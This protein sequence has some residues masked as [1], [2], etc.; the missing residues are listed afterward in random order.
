MNNLRKNQ[1]KLRFGFGIEIL[2]ALAA[3]CAINMT[4]AGTAAATS[5]PVIYTDQGPLTGIKGTG[6]DEF[7]GIPYAAPPVGKL[8]WTAPQ[9]H[10]PWR[11]VLQATHFG[12]ICSQPGGA[13]GEDC[14]FLNIYRPDPLTGIALPVMVWIHGGGLVSGAGGVYDPT[15]LVEKG[16]VIVADFNYRLGVLGFFAHPAL[17]VKGRRN[18]NYGLMDQQFVLKWLQRNIHAFG[19]DA[20]RMTIFGQSAGG[21]SVYSHLAS[22]TAAAAHLFQGAIAESGAYASFER[23]LPFIVPLKTAEQAGTSFASNVGCSSQTAQCL[24]A[25]SAA[26]LVAAQPGI[27]FPCVDGTILTQPPGSAFARGQFNRVPVISGSNH[28]EFRLYVAQSYDYAGHPLKDSQYQDAVTAFFTALLGMPPSNSF[29]QT[30]VNDKYPLKN[31]SPQPPGYQRASLALGAL[32]TDV[33]FA[34]PAR[35]AVMSL[36]KYVK[37]YAYEFNDEHAPLIVGAATFPLGAYH[38]AEVQ[39]L[40]NIDSGRFTPQQ[41]Q[42]SNTMIDYWTHFAKDGNPNSTGVPL[43]S[44]YSAGTDQ[45]QSLVP[46][47]RWSSRNLIPVT[48]VPRYGTR[49]EGKSQMAA[50]R[51][52]AP[53]DFASRM[54]ELRG[55]PRRRRRACF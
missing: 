22:P 9:P 48:S 28:D 49:S 38:S 54:R 10:G 51:A 37:A 13:G 26:K 31:Y 27:V 2:L 29:V 11:G 3:V 1:P 21:V 39:Y 45:Y 19:G 6:I 42:L 34:C 36:S 14:L 8:R 41:Q 15:P 20:N 12:N 53:P 43:W 55:V 7:L 24:H 50:R 30:I 18:A 35:K 32:G 16:G 23:Y 52:E 40:F 25:L 33:A 46:P 5:T 44:S 47:R 4:W 17:D